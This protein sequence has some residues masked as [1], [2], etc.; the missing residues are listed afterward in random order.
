MRKM[1]TVLALLAASG[2]ASSAALAA[3]PQLGTSFSGGN[4]RGLPMGFTLNKKGR[5][6]AAFTGY[7]CPGKDGIGSA[8]SNKPEGK[9]DSEGKLTVTYRAKGLTVT[10]KVR[11]PTRKTARGTITFKSATCKAPKMTFT[12]QVGTES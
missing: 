4:G 10:M 6:T 7:T 9:V 3:K 11:F 8:S 5:A 1:I 2:I 12:A